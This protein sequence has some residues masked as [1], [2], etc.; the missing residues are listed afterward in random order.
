[1]YVAVHSD[2]DCNLHK[3]SMKIEKQYK[4]ISHLSYKC[5]CYSLLQLSRHVCASICIGECV[6]NVRRTCLTLRQAGAD[7]A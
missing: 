4:L 2:C 3:I 7:R 5:V 1:M 6:F